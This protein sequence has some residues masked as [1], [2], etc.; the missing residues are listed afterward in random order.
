MSIKKP[1]YYAFGPRLTNILANIFH[2]PMTLI[3]APQG[4]GKQLAM[5][6][7]IL[8][9]NALSA[10]INIPANA[11][12]KDVWA[13][14]FTALRE[15]STESPREDPF[16]EARGG[17]DTPAVL[18][19]VRRFSASQPAREKVIVIDNFQNTAHEIQE[20]IFNRLYDV[21]SSFIP[22]FHIVLLSDCLFTCAAEK[23]IDGLIQEIDKSLLI[24]NHDEVASFFG[25][26]GFRLK[27]EEVERAFNFS[28]GWLFALSALVIVATGAGA[29][30]D[31]VVSEA[32]RRMRKYIRDSF[33]ESLSAGERTFIMAMSPLET[34]T[35]QQARFACLRLGTDN[36]L[37]DRLFKRQI[38]ID[39]IPE[40]DA[41]RFHSLLR[42]LAEE[43]LQGLPA[44]QKVRLLRVT[45]ELNEGRDTQAAG[46]RLSLLSGREL[47]IYTLLCRGNKYKEIG[48]TLYISENTVKTIIKAIYRKLEVHSR[49]ELTGMARVSGDKHD[50]TG[51]V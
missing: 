34:F 3:A 33:W 27:P 32:G 51:E 50:Q 16:T 47:E 4:Y 18:N 21:A 26:H 6:A 45:E 20:G 31:S 17:I 1:E 48:D 49:R 41:Y 28:E 44:A 2:F 22:R 8:S 25:K 10:W 35:M 7:Y 29:F 30:N 42:G 46:L 23:Y 12:E 11:D 9:T 40:P 38:L 13:R 5:S 19:A 14:F 37:P 39:Y 36:A 15:F 24:I 43:T